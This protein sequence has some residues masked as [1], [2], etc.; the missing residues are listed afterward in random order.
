MS[1]IA[2]QGGFDPGKIVLDSLATNTWENVRNCLPH[3]A[4]SEHVFI[5]SD[6]MHALRAKTYLCRQSPEICPRAHV[7]VQYEPL[8]LSLYK[9]FSAYYT[10][11][12]FL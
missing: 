10:L 12:R 5:V 4:K 2:V 3:V 6:A 1:R 7:A 9:W 8:R 11:I